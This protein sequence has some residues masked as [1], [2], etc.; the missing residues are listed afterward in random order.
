MLR[1]FMGDIEDS[2]LGVDVGQDI[3]HTA[4]RQTFTLIAKG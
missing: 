4:Y 3:W 2:P 1:K